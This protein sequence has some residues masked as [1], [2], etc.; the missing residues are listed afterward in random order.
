MYVSPDTLAN[1]SAFIY[2]GPLEN[3]ANM[4]VLT[5]P[6][7]SRMFCSSYFDGLW[8]GRYMA[9]HL[10]FSGSVASS[11]FWKKHVIFLC[12]SHWIFFFTRFVS[13]QAVNPCG[14]T[15]TATAW[16]KSHFI[17]LEGTDFYMID[18]LSITVHAFVMRML[19]LLSVDEILL[20]MY[21]NPP[22]ISKSCSQSGDNSFVFKAFYLHS[23]RGHCLLLVA[24]GYG[25][26][27]HRCFT[28]RY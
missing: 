13:V 4:I 21:V 23:R 16:K 27:S 28:D 3:A 25:I 8:D 20:P 11:I 10:L 22:L 9:I 1:F 26:F 5:F 2:T 12:T 6:A 24:P 15:D 14:T 7:V 19:T 17:L 18:S